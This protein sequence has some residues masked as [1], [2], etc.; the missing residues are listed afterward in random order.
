M[1]DHQISNKLAARLPLSEPH[2]RYSR[3]FGRAGLD[4][5]RAIHFNETTQFCNMTDDA[6][7]AEMDNSRTHLI[8]VKYSK[9][10][11][12]KFGWIALWKELLVDTQKSWLCQLAIWA[13]F[14]KSFVP[15]P[16]LFF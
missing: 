12:S 5:H 11:A 14:S 4:H 13:I 8:L 6:D 9:A 10:S 15:S 2:S 16:D 1:P 3:K 7:Q